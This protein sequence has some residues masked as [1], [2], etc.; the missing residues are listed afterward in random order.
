MNEL[1]KYMVENLSKSM[2][3]LEIS[4]WVQ[5]GKYKSYL[6]NKRFIVTRKVKEFFRK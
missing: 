5:L 4:S 6:K 1:K 2:K 3:K